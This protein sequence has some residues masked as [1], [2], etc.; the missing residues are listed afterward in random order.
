[1]DAVYNIILNEGVAPG[2]AAKSRSWERYMGKNETSD[3]IKALMEEMFDTYLKARVF[4]Q[5]RDWYLQN[6]VSEADIIYQ[7]YV[8]CFKK[9]EVWN[10][11]YQFA[12]SNE[13][14]ELQLLMDDILADVVFGGEYEGSS[15]EE[16]YAAAFDILITQLDPFMADYAEVLLSQAQPRYKDE[17]AINALKADE[18]DNFLQNA[19]SA[20]LIEMN[21]IYDKYSS[22]LNTVYRKAYSLDDPEFT[23]IILSLQEKQDLAE[24]LQS[25]IEQLLDLLFMEFTFHD[26]AQVHNEISDIYDTLLNRK[27]SLYFDKDIPLSILKRQAV[28]LYKELRYLQA[29]DYLESVFVGALADFEKEFNIETWNRYYQFCLSH[30]AARQRCRIFSPK[31]PTIK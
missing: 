10:Q 27:D 1:M 11:L 20:R 31:P 9:F 4:E 23:D 28:I 29:Q 22:I 3:D 14:E 7:Y 19:D 30:N 16:I 6:S 5:F 12:I 26:L 21:R 24:R 8:D 2:S 25:K 17:A 13:D 18:W 15:E